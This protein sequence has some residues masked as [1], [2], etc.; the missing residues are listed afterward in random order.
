VK[1]K[2]FTE[3]VYEVAAVLR[4]PGRPAVAYLVTPDKQRKY[5]GGAFITLSHEMREQLW[6]RVKANAKPVKALPP[7]RA[8]N[9]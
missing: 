4:E 2:C 1:T 5:V 3:G 7:S 8:R 9:G 6:K